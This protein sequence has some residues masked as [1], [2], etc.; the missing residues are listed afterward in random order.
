MDFTISTYHWFLSA[1]II[2]PSGCCQWKTYGRSEQVFF[3]FSREGNEK[4][5]LELWF[6]SHLRLPDISYLW[7]VRNEAKIYHYHLIGGI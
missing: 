3:L 2:R 7:C 1:E 4:N 5:C 6:L